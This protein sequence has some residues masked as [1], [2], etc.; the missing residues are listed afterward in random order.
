MILIDKSSIGKP[1]VYYA[2]TKIANIQFSSIYRMHF[3]IEELRIS[4]IEA[5]RSNNP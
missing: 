2:P 4:I 5:N 3:R 1:K